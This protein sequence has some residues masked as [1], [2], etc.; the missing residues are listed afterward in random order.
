MGTC[1][2]KD[3]SDKLEAVETKDSVPTAPETVVVE[4]TGPQPREG[5]FVIVLDK[6]NGERLGMDVD[7]EDGRTLAVDAITGGLIAKW[8][9]EHPDKALRPKDRIVEVNGLRGD[10][11]QLVDECKKP[12]V[13]TIYVKRESH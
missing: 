11:L 13:L 8:N 9:E 10:V 12:K 7:H 6:T 1:C 3:E 4:E 2:S 5:E